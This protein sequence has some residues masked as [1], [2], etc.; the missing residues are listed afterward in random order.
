MVYV[1]ELCFAGALFVVVVRMIIMYGCYYMNELCTW[2]V[3]FCV[4]NVSH[5]SLC[6]VRCIV[7]VL[8]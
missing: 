5:M 2:A 7:N 4:F 6:G 8:L 3:V 1:F